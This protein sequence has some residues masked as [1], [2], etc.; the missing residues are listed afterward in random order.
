MAYRCGKC[1]VDP[2]RGARQYERLLW[3]PSPFDIPREHHG[4]KPG[5]LHGGAY[6]LLPGSRVPNVPVSC[7]SRLHASFSVVELL[8]G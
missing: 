5:L 3:H 2:A 1:G 4:K 7:V 8:A 6:A